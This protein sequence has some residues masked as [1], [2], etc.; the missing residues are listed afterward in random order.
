MRAHC[1]SCFSRQ[2]VRTDD[3]VREGQHVRLQKLK[4]FRIFWGCAA[5]VMPTMAAAARV[6]RAAG[7][8][9]REW[10]RCGRRVEYA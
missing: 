10:R 9:A 2:E 3:G 4:E 8:V 1:S 6:E 7:S 5:S